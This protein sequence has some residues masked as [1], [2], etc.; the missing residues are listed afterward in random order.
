MISI[1]QEG[2]SQLISL[3]IWRSIVVPLMSLS[4]LLCTPR[5]NGKSEKVMV[6]LIA[7]TSAPAAATQNMFVNT[8]GASTLG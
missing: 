6:S 5:P 4:V 8:T 1:F 3:N 2:F 7:R